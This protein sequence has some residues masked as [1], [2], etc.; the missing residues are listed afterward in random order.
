[1][2][3][4][5]EEG[6]FQHHLPARWDERL[7]TL[8]AEFCNAFKRANPSFQT[9]FGYPVSAPGRANLTLCSKQVSC[10]HHRPAE[11]ARPGRG[12]ASRSACTEIS[13]LEA[14]FDGF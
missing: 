13:S 12:E 14:M 8:Q 5:T 10:E 7:K 9:Q 6:P 2:Q 1:M 4:C 11:A 3:L